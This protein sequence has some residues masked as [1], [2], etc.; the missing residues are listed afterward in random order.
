MEE[1]EVLLLFKGLLLTQW[2]SY[3]E[4]SSFR[5]RDFVG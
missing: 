5:L 4:G 3:E 2:I 1:V